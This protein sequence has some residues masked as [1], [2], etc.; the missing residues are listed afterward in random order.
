M[1][2]WPTVPLVPIPASG[3]EWPARTEVGPLTR[4]GPVAENQQPDALD[5][6]TETTRLLLNQII[7]MVN[8]IRDFFL[9]RDG[10]VGS[11]TQPGVWMR[12][13]FDM[14]GFKIVKLATA[15]AVTDAI[16]F[17]Q[18][19][20][21][22]FSAQ[23]DVEQILD[24]RVVKLNGSAVLGDELN[25]G[26]FRVTNVGD[27]SGAI[28]PTQPSCM[29]RKDLVDAAVVQL[30]NELLPR[31]G[32][33]FML[34][35]LSFD[36]PVV[37]DPGFIPT[38]VADPTASSH[39]V[40][41]SYLE[42]Q[43]SL[44]DGEDVPVGMTLPFA[45]GT[46]PSN[47]LLCDGR[48]VSRF[49]YQ[50]LFNVIGIAYGTPTSSSVFKLPDM[51]AAVIVGLDNMG[52]ASA[53]RLTNP[54]ADQLGGKFNLGFR[55]MTLGQMPAHTHTYDD[56]VFASGAA[57][58][59]DGAADGTDANNI[60]ADTVRTTTSTGVA[61]PFSIVQPSLVQNYIIRY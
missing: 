25:A 32:S 45:G 21:V 23:D 57:G 8:R 13:D 59:E 29:M 12:G 37:T 14:G 61:D 31:S 18:L 39:L 20:D 38:N 24:S 1:A 15:T 27:P 4:I 2:Q 42:D 26:S 50:N 6:R 54:V 44:F 33:L 35:D 49:V 55:S 52:G 43:L 47:F 48:E 30:T 3:A 19:E 58:A 10:T 17:E 60:Q 9:D 5:T 53:N 34:G 51:R 28:V 40:N 56:H 41:K 22:Q 46:V 36:G 7:D 11:T 16:V